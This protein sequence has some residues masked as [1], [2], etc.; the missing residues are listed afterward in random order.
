MY[1]RGLIIG[2]FRAETGSR[3]EVY[4]R[5]GVEGEVYPASTYLLLSISRLEDLHLKLY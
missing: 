5:L 4:L 2:E 3:G 1:L